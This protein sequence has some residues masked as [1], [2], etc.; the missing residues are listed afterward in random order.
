MP[1]KD[2]YIITIYFV[3]DTKLVELENLFDNKDMYIGLIMIDNYEK[4]IQR[5]PDDEKTQ[6]MAELEKD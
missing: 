4:I 6:L 1:L 3:D 5:I 2:E